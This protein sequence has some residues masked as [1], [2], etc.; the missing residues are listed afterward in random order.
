[1]VRTALIVATLLALP[2]CDRP[3]QPPV[4]IERV[5]EEEVRARLAVDNPVGRYLPVAPATGEGVYVTDTRTGTV[6]HCVAA[7]SSTAKEWQELKVGCTEPSAKPGRD[8]GKGFR[9]IEQ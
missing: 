8:L 6:R 9:E 5:P 3:K 1:M 4:K 7:G 2:G